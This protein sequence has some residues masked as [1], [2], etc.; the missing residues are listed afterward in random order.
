MVSL[1]EPMKNE[2]FWLQTYLFNVRQVLFWFKDSFSYIPAMINEEYQITKL[3]DFGGHWGRVS[4]IVWLIVLI[5]TVVS[6]PWW[7]LI[8]WR[9]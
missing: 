8:W 4:L 7:I 2:S 9:G 1:A 6:L 5:V 3:S